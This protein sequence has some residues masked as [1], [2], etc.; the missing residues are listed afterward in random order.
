MTRSC[1]GAGRDASEKESARHS[2]HL[3]Q[4]GLRKS[5]PFPQDVISRRRPA[6]VNSLRT[7]NLK[8]LKVD[9]SGLGLTI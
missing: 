2:Q 7:F 9:I 6:D 8:A 1:R 3:C 5:Q 4:S